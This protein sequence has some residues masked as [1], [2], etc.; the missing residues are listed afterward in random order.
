MKILHQTG[1]SRIAIEER[2]RPE[3]GPG[4]VLIQTVVSAVCGSEMHT[5]RGAGHPTGNLGH[6]A[7]GIVA[8]QGSGVAS[9]QVGDR[10][11]VSA[12]A[13][14]GA[15]PQCQAGRYTW[16]P[17]Y[18]F[19]ANMHAEYFVVPAHACH[20]LPDDVPWEIGVL[21]TGDALGVPYHTSTKFPADGVERVA[22]FGLGPIGL[23]NVLLQTYLGRHVIGIDRFPERLELA[24]SLGAQ[25]TVLANADTDV[26]AR[27]RELTDGVGADVCIE[28]A[29]VPVTAKQCFAAVRT[30]GYVLFN[31]E[32]P[33]VEL[34]PSSDFIRRDITAT[35]SWFYHF[36]EYPQMLALYRA[37][38]PISS[39]ITHTFPLDRA[40]EAY[41]MME[42]KSG[43]VLLDYRPPGRT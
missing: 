39:L 41:R 14:C 4:E 15:C 21:I 10:V 24:R 1:G 6:E 30:G 2:P 8:G 3:P 38:C 33:A 37:G 7:A 40:D 22:V 16:C 18:T 32:Q 5:Y 13:G 29:G 19:H 28:A 27:I 36:G 34:S 25:H 20:V 42:G 11:G 9:P 35:G 31:G 12:I 23:G 26:P 43:K 17:A